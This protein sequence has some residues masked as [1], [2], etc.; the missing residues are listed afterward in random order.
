MMPAKEQI[1]Q[2]IKELQQI[3]RIC[4]WDI[5]LNYLSAVEMY[6]KTDDIHT[7]AN[8]VRSR[9]HHLATINFCYE[10]NKTGEVVG[11]WYNTIVHEMFHIFIDGFDYAAN[12]EFDHGDYSLPKERLICDISRMFVSLYPVSNFD[13]ILKPEPFTVSNE[14][15]DKACK[16][17]GW[18]L[19]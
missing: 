12:L 14:T 17:Q 13:R 15:I 10:A 19:E 6:K 4:D 7:I 5:E 2:I 8:C 1:E 9:A 16:K 3:M 18:N 11:G